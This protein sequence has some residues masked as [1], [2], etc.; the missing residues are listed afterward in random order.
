MWENYMEVALERESREVTQSTETV[1]Q[2][3]ARALRET[4]AQKA[5]LWLSEIFFSPEDDRVKAQAIFDV[6]TRRS[7]FPSIQLRGFQDLKTLD[8]HTA[9]RFALQIVQ[10]PL[11]EDRDHIRARALA[12]LVELPDITP[13][14]TLLIADG[15]KCKFRT[16]THAVKQAIGSLSRTEL[17]AL[18][19]TAAQWTGAEASKVAPLLTLIDEAYPY[20]PNRSLVEAFQEEKSG[21]RLVFP[22]QARDESEKVLAVNRAS[23]SMFHPARPRGVAPSNSHTPTANVDLSRAS[24]PLTSA[25]RPS[26]RSTTQTQSIALTSLPPKPVVSTAPPSLDE[27]RDSTLLDKTWQELLFERDRQKDPRKLC[28]CIAEMAARFGIELT[29]DATSSSLIFVLS[30]PD[31]AL[32]RMGGALV[33]HLFR[34]T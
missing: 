3:H 16:V 19:E 5:E 25:A 14:E 7:D 20:A 17:S 9:R 26:A 1:T 23:R 12:T 15:L 2:L 33:E 4:C 21:E 28:A 13:V 34:K 22:K 8:P 32:K 27:L 18:R 24:P 11:N 10:E 30:H 6:V 29:R 31:P